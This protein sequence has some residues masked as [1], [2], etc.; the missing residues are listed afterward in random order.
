MSFCCAS[1]SYCFFGD[2]LSEISFWVFKIAEDVSATS[3]HLF[4]HLCVDG[5]LRLV[6]FRHILEIN[7]CLF[8]L[9]LAVSWRF[10]N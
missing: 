10:L 4:T 7:R 1:I 5:Y 3:P 9:Q 6:I 2:F 8:V